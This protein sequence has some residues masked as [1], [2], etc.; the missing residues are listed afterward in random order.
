M[1]FIIIAKVDF[2]M[3]GRHLIRQGSYGVAHLDSSTGYYRVHFKAKNKKSILVS[4]MHEDICKD[5]LQTYRN[6]YTNKPRFLSEDE[7][8]EWL[9]ATTE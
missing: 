4:Q 9:S 3:L 5:L 1:K 7:W 8:K 2:T 6:N